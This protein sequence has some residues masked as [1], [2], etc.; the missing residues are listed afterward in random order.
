MTYAEYLKSQGASDED[1]KILDTPVGRKTYEA[2]LS[3]QADAT[4]ARQGAEAYEKKAN[5]WFEKN[6]AEVKAS[7][8]RAVVES[9]RAAKAE[10]ALKAAQKA[11]LID[12]AKDLGYEFDAPPDKKVET[13]AAL[14]S[15]KYFTKDEILAIAEREGVSIAT[16]QDIAAEHATLFPGQRL[17]FRA[18]REEAVAKRIPLEQL[19]MDRYKIADAR[20]AAQKAADDANVAKWKAEGAKEKEAELVSRFGNPDTRPLTPSTSPFTKRAEANRD[21]QP[22]E[23]GLAGEDGSND[24]VRRATQTF[25]KSSVN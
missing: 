25:L 2:M 17:N 11:G 7:A 16:A 13:P 3:A 15:S 24:R 20:A 10:A 14:D 18:L 9:A 19:W 23:T 8:N 1:V 6:E 4:K 5:E 22:W 21:K 12:V